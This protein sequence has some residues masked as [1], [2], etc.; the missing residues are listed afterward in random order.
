M[1]ELTLP[2]W[3][4]VLTGLWEARRLW[5]YKRYGIKEVHIWYRAMVMFEDPKYARSFLK[6]IEGNWEKYHVKQS[7]FMIFTML[8]GLWLLV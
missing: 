8:V 1:S 2:A 5:R 6:N 7:W 3:V 4:L